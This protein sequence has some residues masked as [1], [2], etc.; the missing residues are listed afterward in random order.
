M[1]LTCTLGVRLLEVGGSVLPPVI[2]SWPMDIVVN[3]PVFIAKGTVI[4]PLWQIRTPSLVPDI[5]MQSQVSGQ[6]VV[7]MARTCPS[8]S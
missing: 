1:W 4:M 5:V 2:G 7:W 8:T 6:S 3:T